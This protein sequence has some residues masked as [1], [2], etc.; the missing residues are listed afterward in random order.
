MSSAHRDQ[1]DLD[2]YAAALRIV[3]LVEAEPVSRSVL[4]VHLVRGDDVDGAFG[5]ACA[6]GRAQE[7][8]YTNHEG[9]RVRWAFEA[10]ETLDLL[11]SPLVDGVEVYSEPRASDEVRHLAFDA[12]FSPETTPPGQSGV[13][14]T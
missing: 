1:T 14:P 5:A 6:L 7:E 9:R 13:P 2:W 10:V 4:Q 11:P 8:V 12:E 3:V